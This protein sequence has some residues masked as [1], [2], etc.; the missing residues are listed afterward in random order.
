VLRAFLDFNRNLKQRC[1]SRINYLVVTFALSTLNAKALL[2]FSPSSSFIYVPCLPFEPG[3][4][5]EF[6]DKP[7]FLTMLL[8]LTE[9]IFLLLLC[10]M[11]KNTGELLGYPAKPEKSR[12][13]CSEIHEVNESVFLSIFVLSRYHNGGNKE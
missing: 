10:A 12:K 1:C 8:L 3:P 5:L 11:W 6:P 9:T 4:V 13:K 7:M 2:F